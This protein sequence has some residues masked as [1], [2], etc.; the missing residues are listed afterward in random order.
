[1]IL[2][3][4]TWDIFW[5]QILQGTGMA[6][7]FVPLTTIT[8]EMIPREETGYATSLYSVMRNIG[9]SVGISFVTTWLARRSQVHQAMLVAH[10]TPYDEPFRMALRQAHGVMMGAGSDAT[11]AN[12]QGMEMIYRTVQQQASLLSF[13]ETFRIL[14]VLFLLCIG[15]VLIMKKPEGKRSG[16]RVME[17]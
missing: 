4:G 17:H 1:M 9:S 15:V 6:F 5:C 14:G 3:S 11:T 13:V 10:V 8:M 2:S 16:E 12:A 7:V